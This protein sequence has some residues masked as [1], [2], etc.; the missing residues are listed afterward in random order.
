MSLVASDALV[1][2]GITGDLARKKIFVALHDMAKRGTLT[3]PVIGVARRDWTAEELVRRAHEA[4]ETY[5]DG[6]DE[7]AF[8]ELAQRLRYVKGDYND[9]DT[10]R[11]LRAEL[12]DSQTPAH[13]LAIPPS[14]FPEVIRE[15]SESGSARGARVIVE[16]PFG[17][18]LESARTLNET[19][20]QTF[21]ESRIFRI[22]HYL[23][24]EPV[25]NLLYF[26]FANAFLEPIWNRNFVSSVQITMAESFGVSGRG[27]FYEET[28]AIRDVFQNHL[29]Q[30]LAILAMEPP[31]RDDTDSVRNEKVKVLRAIRTLTPS[32]VIRGQFRGYRQEP[33]VDPKSNV[34]T[35]AAARLH[36]DSWRWEGVP[37]FVRTGK[38]LPVTATEVY[39]S[40]RRPPQTVFKE[41]DPGRDFVRFRLGP[42]ISIALGARAKLPGEGMRGEQVELVVCRQENEMSAYERL[43]SDALRGDATLFARQDGVEVAWRIVDPVL[44]GDKAPLAYDPGTWGPREASQLVSNYDGWYDPKDG[45]AEP[46]LQSAHGD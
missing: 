6:V 37:F 27:S 23:G 14:L 33:G 10:F 32:D 5:G 13:Y 18:D 7:K 29:L 35:F 30:V 45:V 3:V 4:V 26:R 8:A 16:K 19:L 39:V 24:K 38:C 28:G 31:V 34:E 9:P 21:P 44:P 41:A 36:I 17:R 2:Y 12:G 11:R 43:L 40:L 22:D 20:Q 15:L 42:D 1:F 25:Q 46:V